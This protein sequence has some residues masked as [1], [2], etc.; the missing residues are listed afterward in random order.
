MVFLMVLLVVS[1]LSF[2][3]RLSGGFPGCSVWDSSDGGAAGVEGRVF[4][5]SVFKCGKCRM[6]GLIQSA[7]SAVSKEAISVNNSAVIW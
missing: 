2:L 3:P 7:V 6:D 5:R 1:W 4:G